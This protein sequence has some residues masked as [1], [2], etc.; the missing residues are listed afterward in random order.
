MCPLVAPPLGFVGWSV[1]PDALGGPG[2]DSPG[3]LYF[4]LSFVLSRRRGPLGGESPPEVLVTVSELGCPVIVL[5]L[6]SPCGGFVRY[7]VAFFFLGIIASGLGF[8]WL[9][10]MRA[11]R[12]YLFVLQVAASHRGFGSRR[13][14]FEESLGT[15]GASVRTS[16]VCGFFLV[17]V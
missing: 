17:L 5:L 12:A 11:R 9:F 3:V 8:Q 4:P 7:F 6:R 16:G 10:E 1:V 14:N 13:R 2:L 15:C